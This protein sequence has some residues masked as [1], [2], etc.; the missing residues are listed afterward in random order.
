MAVRDDVQRVAAALTRP[1]AGYVQR[2]R[3]DATVIAA[4]S[5]EAARHLGLF[6]ERVADLTTD[7]LRELYDETFG[8]GPLDDVG[9][10]ASRLASHRTGTAEARVALDAFARMLDRLEADRNPFAWVVRALCC[11][12]LARANTPGP[13][14]MTR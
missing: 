13:A 9:P 10:L 12:L 4:R 8:H 14:P 6:V 5:G 1:G 3:A 2:I 11:V 7:E